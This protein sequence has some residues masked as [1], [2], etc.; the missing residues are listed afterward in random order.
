MT[1]PINTREAP[2]VVERSSPPLVAAI[3][4][5]TRAAT[6]TVAEGTLRYETPHELDDFVTTLTDG[7]PLQSFAYVAGEEAFNQPDVAPP[8]STSP[9][10][11]A[12]GEPP[13][14]SNV[15]S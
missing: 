6:A 9:R 2:R 11:R 14:F 7:A 1:P 13:H 4:N 10:K 5:T 15:S 3:T 12:I 8:I